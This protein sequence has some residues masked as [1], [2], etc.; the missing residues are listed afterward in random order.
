M[1]TEGP[2]VSA[3]LLILEDDC[4]VRRG[5]RV[6]L[7][8]AGYEVV[9]T[10]TIAEAGELL[11]GSSYDLILL[12]LGLPDGDG[13]DFCRQ[14]RLEG[15]A[16]PIVVVTARDAPQDLVRGLDAGADDYVTKPFDIDEVLAR[17]RSALRRGWRRE[18]QQVF[19]CGELWADAESRVAGCGTE[20]VDC[21]PREFDLLLFLLRHPGRA[22]TR[23]QLLA[24][25]WG[26]LGGVGDSR[27]VDIHI[28]KLRRKVEPNPSE[29]KYLLTVW[30]VGY[31]M[32]DEGHEP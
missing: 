23:D 18:T 31:R 26:L 4:R 13:G 16:T 7:T 17:I 15:N 25:V 28:R 11:E 1:P 14:L 9:D 6:A 22:W 21:A 19:Q 10:G 12:D 5:L 29:P 27:T 20:R 24:E 3:R 32:N 8:G 30:G 2:R